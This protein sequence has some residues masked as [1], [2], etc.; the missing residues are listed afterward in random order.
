M[1][2]PTFDFTLAGTPSTPL[3]LGKQ[4]PTARAHTHLASEVVKERATPRLQLANSARQIMFSANQLHTL[5]TTVLHNCCC[6]GTP[7]ILLKFVRGFFMCCASGVNYSARLSGR[8]TRCS[9][10]DYDVRVLQQPVCVF[11]ARR[12]CRRCCLPNLLDAARLRL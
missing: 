6:W 10:Y 2:S 7:S 8:C 12:Q 9:Y 11:G 4:P 1:C 3:F 5:P